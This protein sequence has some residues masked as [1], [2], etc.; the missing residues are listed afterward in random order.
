MQRILL[1]G[2]RHYVG[3]C[4]LAGRIQAIT[5]PV[6]CPMAAMSLQIDARAKYHFKRQ[7]LSWVVLAHDFNPSTWEADASR[8]L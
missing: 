3:P 1:L 2:F 5:W 7:V 8:S 4:Y 6:Q